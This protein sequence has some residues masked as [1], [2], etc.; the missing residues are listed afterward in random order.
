M[1]IATTVTIAAGAVAVAGAVVASVRA[2][3]RVE[4]KLDQMQRDWYGEAARP[5][6]A[7]IPGVPERLEIIEKQLKP[8]GGSTPVDAINRVELQLNRLSIDQ[9][10]LARRLDE[11]L[12][13]SNALLARY[14]EERGQLPPA[15]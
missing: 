2:G 1:D 11:H 7:A 15:T 4:R 10:I 8:N 6:F 14:M 13:Q 5:G 3:H 12:G 9:G